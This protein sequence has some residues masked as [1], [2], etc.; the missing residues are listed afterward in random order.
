M[1]DLQLLLCHHSLVFSFGILLALSYCKY[2]LSYATVHHVGCATVVLLLFTNFQRTGTWF[3]DVGQIQGIIFT[4]KSE[5]FPVNVKKSSGSISPNVLRLKLLGSLSLCA[6]DYDTSSKNCVVCFRN[7]HNAYANLFYL[8]S[9]E[10]FLV[11]L[12]GIEPMTS[13]Y[14]LSSLFTLP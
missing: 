14:S 4:A 1:R 7:T 6:L 11:E 10:L 5:A 8:S 2:L 13:C 12:I 3:G 9:N